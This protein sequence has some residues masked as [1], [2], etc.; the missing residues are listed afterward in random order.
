MR[1]TTSPFLLGVGFMRTHVPWY[2][3]QKWFD[4]F[5]VE[6]I[7]TPPYLGG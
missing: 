5:P 3:P 6:D 1:A 2:V 7:V 4:M